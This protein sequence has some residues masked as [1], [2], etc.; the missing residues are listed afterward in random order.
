VSN[1]PVILVGCDGRTGDEKRPRDGV[2]SAYLDAV[3]RAGGVPLIMPARV[4]LLEELLTLADGVLLPGGDDL[5]PRHFGEADT[6]CE[7]PYLDERRVG[8]ELAI[9][10]RAFATDRPLLGI[11]AGGQLMNVALG[12]S[13]IQHLGDKLP[14]HR[15]PGEKYSARHP[16]HIEGGSGLYRILGKSETETNSSHHQAIGRVADALRVTARSPDGV[17]EA[18]EAPAKRFY[19]GVQWHPETDPNPDSLKLFQAFIDS[20]R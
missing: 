18:V 2:Y 10:R 19:I 4:A 20:C 13:L 11:C 1:K 17:V 7:K 8:L 16:I 9:L 6:G 3:V 15:Q 12:G 14:T 5:D